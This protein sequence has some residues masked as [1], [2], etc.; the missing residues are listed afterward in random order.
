M[1]KCLQ[2]NKE[3]PQTIGKKTRLFCND[4][5]RKAY[6]RANA[7]KIS[8]S[9]ADNSKADNIISIEDG[10]SGQLTKQQLSHPELLTDEQRIGKAIKGYCHGCGRDFTKIKG[11]T[12]DDSYFT[13]EKADNRC[14]CF[15]CTRKGI[16]HQSLGLETERQLLEKQLAEE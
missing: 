6:S 11:L 4:A 12:I 8:N 2:C 5:C 14:I 13:Q 7:D 1:N 9:K 16:T 10:K 15:H 3:V